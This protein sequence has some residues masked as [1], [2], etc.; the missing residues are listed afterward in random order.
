MVCCHKRY[1]LGDVM[2]RTATAVLE[3]IAQELKIDYD[4][5][6]DDWED[7]DLYAL[8]E[9]RAVILPLFLFDHSGLSMS[10]SRPACPWDSGQVGYIWARLED[11]TAAT[12][13]AEVE[14]YS[15]YLQGD[16]YRYLVL[17]EDGTT[18]L[19]E[20]AGIFGE[21]EAEA[22]GQEC[23]EY[24]KKRLCQPVKLYKR[25][26]HLEGLYTGHEFR[27]EAGEAS[28]EHLVLA[29]RTKRVFLPVPGSA[30]VPYIITGVMQEI[31]D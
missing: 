24:W 26:R 2:M 21:A 17:D 3:H 12:L 30:S 23:L 22:Q 14:V 5:T 8:I 27:V 4:D 19:E 13:Q 25:I 9:Q 29:M 6:A 28:Y 31:V 20:N 10:T 18:I 15:L 11:A 1:G 16:V 7:A